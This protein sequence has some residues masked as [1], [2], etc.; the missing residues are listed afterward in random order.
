MKDRISEMFH[1]YNNICR[2]LIEIWKNLLEKTADMAKQ[3]Q[4]VADLLHNQIS[5][6]MKQQKR[7][8]EAAFKRV[9]NNGCTHVRT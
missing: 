8:K 2:G 1:E 7:V 6:M 5:E 4:Q 3:K 9:S